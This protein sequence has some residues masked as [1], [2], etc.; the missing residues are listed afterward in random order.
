MLC[1]VQPNVCH[2]IRIDKDD[3]HAMLV[4]A[5]PVGW[6][7]SWLIASSGATQKASQT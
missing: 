4:A 7:A 5:I 2:A 3:V 6:A 1:S